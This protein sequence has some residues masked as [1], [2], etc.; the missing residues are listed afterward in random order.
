MNQIGYAIEF[1]LIVGN[2]E[3]G[4]FN[5][6]RFSGMQVH[7]PCFVRFAYCI[8]NLYIGMRGEPLLKS[9]KVSGDWSEPCA[10]DRKLLQKRAQYIE[11]QAFE[12]FAHKQGS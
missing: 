11:V 8:T 5:G 10:E 4:L 7:H 1:C 2:G 12:K 6:K 9:W 3:D